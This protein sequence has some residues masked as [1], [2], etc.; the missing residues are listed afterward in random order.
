MSK[1]TV[2]E[3]YYFTVARY[4]ETISNFKSAAKFYTQA[5]VIFKYNNILSGDPSQV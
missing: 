3:A 5:L 1:D 2:L 4:S